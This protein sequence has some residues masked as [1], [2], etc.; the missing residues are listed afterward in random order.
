MTSINLS[1]LST[2]PAQQKAAFERGTFLV[3]VSSKL[4]VLCT[5]GIY[6]VAQLLLTSPQDAARKC[7]ISPIEFKTAIEAV[8]RGCGNFQ[9][10]Y[11]DDIK[12]EGDELFSTGDPEIDLALGGGIRTGMI[13]ELVGE[14]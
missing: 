6:T 4:T 1:T 3:H 13:W 9:L 5:G 2:L 7:R 10:Q 14:R 12:S 11:L 8:C